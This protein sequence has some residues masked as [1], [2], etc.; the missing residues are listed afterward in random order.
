MHLPFNTSM[1]LPIEVALYEGM[2]PLTGSAG[3]LTAQVTCLESAERYDTAD[4]QFRASPASPGLALAARGAPHAHVY[5]NNLAITTNFKRGNYRVWIKNNDTDEEFF[6]NFTIGLHVNRTLGVTAVYDGTDLTIG[7]WVEENGEIQTDYTGISSC[8][9]VDNQGADVASGSI[10]LSGPTNGVF[11]AT[12]T[13]ELDSGS[14]LLI[15]GVAACPKPGSGSFSF[16][17]RSALIRP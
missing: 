9:L 2:T 1:I 17:L 13:I 3:D 4:G 6:Q 15:A 16:A 11:Y 5:F 10:T 14:A 8:K 12:K 7:V